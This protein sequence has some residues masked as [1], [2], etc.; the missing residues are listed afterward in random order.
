MKLE[1]ET[2]MVSYTLYHLVEAET[3]SH[4][5]VTQTLYMSLPHS[6]AQNK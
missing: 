6:L 3:G 1:E 5:R 4:A 2:S